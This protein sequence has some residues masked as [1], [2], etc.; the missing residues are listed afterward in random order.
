MASR[1]T[2]A[3]YT[4][5]PPLDEPRRSRL[6]FGGDLLVFKGV[7]SLKRLSRL[8]EAMISESGWSEPDRDPTDASAAHLRDVIAGVQSRFGGDPGIR[9]AAVEALEEVGV[10]VRKA[11]WDWLYFRVQTPVSG[12]SSVGTLGIHRDTW[13]SNVYAQTNWWTPIRPID[14]ERT[15]AF[16]PQYWSKPLRNTSAQWDLEDIRAR[17]RSGEELEGVPLVPVPREDPDGPELR[18][19]VEPG[20]ILCFSGAHVHAS[21]PN[22]TGETRF[23]LEVRTVHE[24]DLLEDD[25]AP[26]IDG[27]APRRPL[28]WFKGILSGTSLADLED[29]AG[30]GGATDDRRREG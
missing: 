4:V 22:T 11:Y 18:I 21:V 28:E 9:Q 20:D 23:S 17:R 14:R 1:Q 13:S 12:S 16:Y 25:G 27:D 3:V 29:R 26:N 30:R 24:I 5:S 15:I 2:C 10:D 19:V 6:A 7:E 8:A